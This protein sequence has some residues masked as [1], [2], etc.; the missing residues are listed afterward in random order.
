M[1]VRTYTYYIIFSLRITL[2]QLTLKANNGNWLK[3]NEPDLLL[4]LLS[5]EEEYFFKVY[6]GP[7]T[8]NNQNRFTDYYLTIYDHRWSIYGLPQCAQICPIR[9]LSH[10]C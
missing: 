4:N 3:L 5:F 7:S 6:M 8:K 1:Y 9:S 2:L 10:C